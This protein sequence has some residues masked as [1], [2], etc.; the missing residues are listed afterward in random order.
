MFMVTLLD[1]M[2]ERGLISRENGKWQLRIP[3]DEIDLSVPE[4]L[5][6]MI[7]AQI[8]HLTTEEQRALEVASV[9]GA[10]FS[11]NV[12][13]RAMKVD[14]EPLEELFERLSRRS[15]IVRAA[16]SQQLAGGQCFEF[17]H[18]LYREVLDRRQ[19]PMRRAALHLSIGRSLEDL[20]SQR[21]S[22]VA[23][24]LAGQFEQGGDWKR[25]INYLGLAADTGGR[26]FEPRQSTE[27][28]EHALE[29][30]KKLPEAAR[31][32]SETGI[33]ERLARIYAALGD[34]RVSETYAALSEKAAHYGLIDVEV[35]ALVEWAF[36][37]SWTSSERG[38]EL[39]E[40]AFR[41]VQKLEPEKHLPAYAACLFFRLLCGWNPQHAE[42]YRN[43][44]GEI[45]KLQNRHIVGP[46]LL[47]YSCIQWCSSEYRE[48]H[49]S[50]AEGLNM[51]LDVDRVHPSLTSIRWGLWQHLYAFD[52]VFLGEWGEAS[53]ELEEAIAMAHRN[54]D[55]FYR[56]RP[57]Q[58]SLAW[59]HLLACD[60][61]GVLTICESAIPLVRDAA[62]RPAP[63][64][65]PPFP[66][67]FQQSLVLRGS[68]E[69]GLGRYDR[70]REY[71]FAARDDMDSR[72]NL[73]DWYWQMPLESALTELWLAERDLTQAR[74]QAERFLS[75]TLTTAER[76][77]QALAWE[78][79]ARVA[80]AELDAP[81]AQE[82]IA[83]ALSTME[84]FEL[85]LAAWRV[86]GT[87]FE[88]YQN[89]A[90]GDSA[91]RHL[92]LSRETI[93]KLA[94]SLRAVDPLRQI[95]LSAPMVGKILG[96]SEIP[97]SHARGA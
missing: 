37:A 92:E 18:A 38:L 26:R 74:W 84:G 17:V 57:L 81:R 85:P 88:L 27:I 22:E 8:D 25:A 80:M 47:D 35:R 10:L 29:L 63:G 13:A 28:L 15:H 51:L 95:F 3:L 64:S 62:L 87:A 50:H 43:A 54:G 9:A 76:T 56:A 33:L 79:N 19:T 75:L 31:G 60:F 86:H 78:A 90:E 42:E 48:S 52:L 21:L 23:A 72:R 36:I 34:A 69:A 14:A 73:N 83:R 20:F 97:S 4:T 94:N 61:A 30:V 44:I 1:H 71:L 55:Y 11:A 7:E 96:D 6:H 82:C 24:E 67:P 32:V 68:A 45:R 46:H 59:L 58:I 41:L 12:V 16:D 65:P 66:W 40:Q 5:R 93:V 70:A 89:S 49:R 91:E 39:L 2:I 53:R 77:W